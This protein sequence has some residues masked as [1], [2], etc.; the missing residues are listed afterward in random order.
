MIRM[1]AFMADSYRLI[2]SKPKDNEKEKAPIEDFIAQ[3]GYDNIKKIL[4]CNAGSNL[5]CY[6]IFY[7]DGQP[8]TPRVE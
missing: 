7:E 6:S 8:Y 3:V 4:T 5:I 2:L 1:K